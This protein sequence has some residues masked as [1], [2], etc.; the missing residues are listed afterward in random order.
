MLILPVRHLSWSSSVGFGNMSMMSKSHL[1]LC[2]WKSA[3]M[4]LFNTIDNYV[5]SSKG[6]K[7]R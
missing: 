7:M 3:F 5:A 1:D 4:D 2:Q 6:L